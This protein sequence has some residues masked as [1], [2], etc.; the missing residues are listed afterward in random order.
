M[1]RHPVTLAIRIRGARFGGWIK[2]AVAFLPVWRRA[3]RHG[4]ILVSHFMFSCPG[5]DKVLDSSMLGGAPGCIPPNRMT[6][7]SAHRT[8]IC[9]SCARSSA[10]PS[11]HC[12]PKLSSRCKLAWLL[13]SRLVRWTSGH[14]QHPSFRPALLPYLLLSVLIHVRRGPWHDSHSSLHLDIDDCHN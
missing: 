9:S 7:H 6:F 3:S 2:I 13:P 8:R 11:S 10:E 5:T 4:S 12:Q 1:P 14:V